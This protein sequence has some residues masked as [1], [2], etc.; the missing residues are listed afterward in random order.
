M[1][2]TQYPLLLL[3]D[4]EISRLVSDSDVSEEGNHTGDDIWLSGSEGVED[5]V[6]EDLD[7]DIDSAR[8]CW[9]WWPRTAWNTGAEH[10][11]TGESTNEKTNVY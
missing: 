9:H 10:S 11:E 4:Y 3:E 5:A 2:N 1:Y 7:C 6:K 8:Y